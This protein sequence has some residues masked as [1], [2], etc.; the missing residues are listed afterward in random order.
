MGYPQRGKNEMVRISGRWWNVYKLIEE[1]KTA[2]VKYESKEV[3]IT[4]TKTKLVLKYT[5]LYK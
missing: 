1:N 2:I 5:R 3:H 4:N